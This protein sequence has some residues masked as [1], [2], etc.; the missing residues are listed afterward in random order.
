MEQKKTHELGLN[1]VKKCI[2]KI[3]ILRLNF[4]NIYVLGA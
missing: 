1:F 2:N 3:Y 4:V